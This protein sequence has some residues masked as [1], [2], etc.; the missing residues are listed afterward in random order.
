MADPMYRVVTKLHVARN[1]TR[2][3]HVDTGPWHPQEQQAQQWA[4]RF[5]ST[6]HYCAVFV[7][8]NRRDAPLTTHNAA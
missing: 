4:D 6:G 1:G 7:E 8:S 3:V 5:R 2:K